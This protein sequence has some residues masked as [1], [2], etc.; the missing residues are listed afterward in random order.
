MK[1]YQMADHW[2]G[3][4]WIT[5]GNKSSVIFTGTKAIGRS[6]YGFANGVLWAYDCAEQNPPTCPEVPAFPNENR[7]YWAEDYQAQIIFYD[8]SDFASVAAGKMDTWEPQ[9]YATLVLD[10]HLFHPKLDLAESKR[11]IVMACA[12]DREHRLLFIVERLAD[13]YKSVIHVWKVNS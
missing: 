10:S 11:D 6:W 3:G 9:P 2:T 12:F 13:G 7:G 5:S 4:A 8:P 1:D